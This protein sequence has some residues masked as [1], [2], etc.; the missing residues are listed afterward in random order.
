MKPAF[1]TVACPT[2]TLETIAKQAA[3]WGY[4]GVELRSEGS[5]ASTTAC[6][7]ALTSAS[8]VRTLLGAAG[9]DVVSLGTSIRFDDPISPP[10][11][12]RT[13][14]FDQ[15]SSVR[16]AKSAIDLAVQLECPFVRVFGFEIIN[17]ESRRSAI[18]RIADR[19]GK[20]LDYARNSGV[21]IALEN[22]GSFATASQLM[23]VIDA[24]DHPLLVASY[25]PSV[26][27][28]AGESVGNGINVIGDRLAI[29][30]IRDLKNGVPCLLGEGD[31]GASQAV[32]ALKAARFGG[33]VIYEND[34]AFLPGGPDLST[35][36]AHAA[37]TLFDWAGDAVRTPSRAQMQVR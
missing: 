26:A 25:S 35:A 10:V 29:A 32:A 31:L 21:K 37:R 15:E 14:L 3:A 7:P 9:V 17:M 27:Q 24:L 12:G 1:S 5:A 6:D 19:L 20:A 18:A 33:W 23:E 16:E 11:I 8:K 13:F 34:S 36:L 30:R 2:W 28:A 22:G 4:L